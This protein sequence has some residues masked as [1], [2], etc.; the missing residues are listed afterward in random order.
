MLVRL[1]LATPKTLEHVQVLCINRTLSV[2]KVA[3]GAVL[4]DFKQLILSSTFFSELDSTKSFVMY[5]RNH[6]ALF[7][8]ASE[9][10]LLG[11]AAPTKKHPACDVKIKFI[12]A[13]G[14]YAPPGPG[15]LSKLHTMLAH[16]TNSTAIKAVNYPATAGNPP[17]MD[18][19][20]L[21]AHDAQ[22]QIMKAVD[23]C[24]DVQIVLTGYSQVSS[25]PLFESLLS[26][27]CSG[28]PRC[29]RCSLRIS[30]WRQGYT[31]LTRKIPVEQ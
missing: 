24:P 16:V 27:V 1:C 4:S 10:V 20:K 22:A 28:C 3:G 26:N 8:L 31:S 25:L 19:V 11:H 13:R 2:R 21:G 23:R 7:L 5:F 29:S 15:G 9:T 18:S 30:R 14:T 6:F 17:Y 12:G